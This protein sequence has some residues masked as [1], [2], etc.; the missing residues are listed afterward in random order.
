[1]SIKS[2][3]VAPPTYDSAARDRYLWETLNQLVEEH[4][5]S[6]EQIM[7]HFPSYILRRDLTRFLSHYELFKKVID[8]PGCIVE[9]GVWK[10][11]SFFTWHKL[12]EIFCPFD[13]SRKIFGFD[14]FS[15]LT[16]FSDKDGAKHEGAHKVEGGYSATAEF[17]RTLVKLNNSDNLI[18]GTQ[19]SLLIEGDLK[20]TLP[21]FLEQNPG[22]KISLLHF[23]VD[24]YE[25]TAFGMKLLYPLVLQGGVVCFDEYGLIPWQ[26]ETNAVDEYFVG[27]SDAPRICKH[28]F[29]QTPHGY[30]V[31]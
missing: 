4:D 21:R 30:F 12:M 9:L 26:G 17:V 7:R 23:D 25:P 22:L 2:E 28:Q 10:G 3:A 24:L 14:H 16:Q 1:M 11:S 8:L 5:E 19:R 18:P 29:T 27:R 6:L 13:R 31:K 15:G 20:E